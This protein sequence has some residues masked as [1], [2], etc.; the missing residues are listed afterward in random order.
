M[1]LSGAWPGLAGGG[2]WP[3]ALW[4]AVGRC[5]IRFLHDLPGMFKLQEPLFLLGAELHGFFRDASSIH[6]TILT[7]NDMVEH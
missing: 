3:A 6:V 5:A 4:F 1:P 7:G 2:G